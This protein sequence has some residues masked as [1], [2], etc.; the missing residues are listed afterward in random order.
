MGVGVEVPPPYAAGSLG[1]SE[2][3]ACS[4]VFH[5]HLVYD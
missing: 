2:F 4:Y 5:I 3:S 1:F